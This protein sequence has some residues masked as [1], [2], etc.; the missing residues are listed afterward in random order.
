[1][2][3]RVLAVSLIF[4]ALRTG[5]PAA[6]TPGEELARALRG[7]PGIERVVL[8]EGK[9]AVHEK[10]EYT[11]VVVVTVNGSYGRIPIGEALDAF[12]SKIVTTAT[13]RLKPGKG[14]LVLRDSRGR[15][16]RTVS[17]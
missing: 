13:D 15:T 9:E 17:F 8:L 6:A 7:T 3:L 14:L 11:H 10:V 12:H 16:L 2:T 4:I 1:M 5:S